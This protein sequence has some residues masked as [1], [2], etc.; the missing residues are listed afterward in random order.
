M[1]ETKKND[2]SNHNNFFHRYEISYSNATLVTNVPSPSPLQ[3]KKKERKEGKKKK[4]KKRRR[5]EKKG[6]KKGKKEE[7]K[8]RKK[9]T[10]KKRKIDTQDTY[11]TSSMKSRTS[12]QHSTPVGPAPTTANVSAA[13]LCSSVTVGRLARSKQLPIALKKAGGKTQTCMW[14]ITCGGREEVQS[15]TFFS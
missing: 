10:K 11:H 6:K 14:Q 3:K 13:V 8:R 9:E 12:A 1:I 4:K 5:E 2:L 15:K 7:T